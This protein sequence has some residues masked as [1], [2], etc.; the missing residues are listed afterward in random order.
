MD[1]VELTDLTSGGLKALAKDVK[2]PKY[3]RM[4]TEKLREELGKV[5]LSEH[6]LSKYD[7]YDFAEEDKKVRAEPLENNLS[8]KARRSFVTFKRRRR[9]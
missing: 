2:L 4:N 7:Q 3:S 5:D 8:L 1:K 6:D 9:R